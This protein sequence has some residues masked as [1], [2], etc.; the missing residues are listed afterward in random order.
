[1]AQTSRLIFANQLRG[2]AALC[3]VVS[4][5][6]GV[7]WGDPVGLGAATATPPITGTPPDIFHLVSQPWFNPGPFG[8]A[9]FFLISGLVIPISLA[10]HSTRT[11]L[12]ARA[13]RIYPTAIIALI[14]E[15]AVIRANAAHWGLAIPFGRSAEISN[16]LLVY[17]LI[18][19]ASI[20]LV[21]WTLCTELK[22]Y[23]VMA[24]LAAPVQRGRLLPLFAAAL[25]ITALNL[26]YAQGS[27]DA[28]AFA[29]IRM[30]SLESVFI[31][32]MLIGVL[33]NYHLRGLLT[34]PGLIAGVAGMLALFAISWRVSVMH[35]DF[36]V[37]AWQYV[38]GLALF[39][40]AYCLRRHAIRMRILDWL[41]A[42]SFPLYLVHLVLGV[43]MMKWLM[44]DVELPY[45]PSLAISL[46]VVLAVA[47]LLH[48]GIE[49][50]STAWGSRLA[51]APA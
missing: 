50:Q 33:F 8:V 39:A 49:R 42:I 5:L 3:V 38:F 31:I 41:A 17:D 15:I 9:V 2:L 6:V 30:A 28:P 4:H 25:L 40:V 10:R 45:Y 44:L 27:F 35:A 46:V 21:N 19:R 20:D 7:Y 14:L 32:F 16:L 24:L 29:P 48:M 18:G 51:V 34:A 13:L 12:I 23:L 43:S 37:L 36:P 1:M 26:G 47:T 22:F 11:F